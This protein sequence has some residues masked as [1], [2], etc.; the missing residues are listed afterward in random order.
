[1]GEDQ[2]AASN[3]GHYMSHAA[4][5]AKARDITLDT[6]HGRGFL[7]DDP[8]GIPRRLKGEV[9]LPAEALTDIARGQ[10]GEPGTR[11]RWVY[12]GVVYRGSAAQVEEIEV[13]TESHTV[14]GEIVLAR[15][16]EAWPE[17]AKAQ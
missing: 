11:R 3:D 4:F 1:M 5:T 9:R 17:S 15:I 14:S 10:L 13:W 7:E 2:K 6:Y 16:L 8:S 12:N